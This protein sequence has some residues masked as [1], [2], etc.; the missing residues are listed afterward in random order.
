MRKKCR[1]KRAPKMIA[2]YLTVMSDPSLG[3]DN[4]A[5]AEWHY[6]HR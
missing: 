4:S 3:L 5:G 6:E 1:E 2:T